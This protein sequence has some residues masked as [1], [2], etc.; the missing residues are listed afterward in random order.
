VTQT[1][2]TIIRV[3]DRQR[4]ASVLAA[5]IESG[6]PGI[7]RL[8]TITAAVGFLLAAFDRDSWEFRG[9]ALA[10]I[11]AT[12]GTALASAGANALNMWYEADADRRM[13]RTR[14]RPIPT[15]RLTRRDTMRLGALLSVAGVLLTLVLAGPASA[16][17]C[18]ACVASYILVY[19]PMKTR[20]VWN[21]L[22]GTIP[23]ALPPMIGA[24]AASEKV[25]ADALASPLGW[26]LVILMVVWQIPHFLAIAW[27]YRDDYA[28][29]GLRM[30]PVVDGH[31]GL[32][33]AVIVATAALLIPASLLPVAA[34]PGLLGPVTL[35]IATLSGLAYLALCIRLAARRDDASAKRVFFASIIHLPLLLVVM[36]ADAGLGVI[37]G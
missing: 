22:L 13:H 8:V 33:A 29:G 31:G 14:G 26:S 3:A 21:T 16:M 37:F 25:G 4:D 18:L 23:G 20:T 2:P 30:L 32:T 28:R 36:V 7:T 35:S 24:A 1:T 12:L 11:G 5:A 15:G 19:T 34:G 9:L 17:I 27:L 6:K 10:A